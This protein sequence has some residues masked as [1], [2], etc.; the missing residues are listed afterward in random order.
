MSSITTWTHAGRVSMK[1]TSIR[2]PDLPDMLKLR[3]IAM[4]G[5]SNQCRHLNV[6]LLYIASTGFLNSTEHW[7]VLLYFQR[8]FKICDIVSLL[9]TTDYV[10]VESLTILKNKKSALDRFAGCSVDFCSLR[11]WI[12][13]QP[14]NFKLF[15]FLIHL[16][17]SLWLWQIYTPP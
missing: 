15:E 13:S 5:E 14:H 3:E 16:H 4:T 8:T 9:V 2:V 11:D 6:H 1:E 7:S 12:K 17:S 10:T